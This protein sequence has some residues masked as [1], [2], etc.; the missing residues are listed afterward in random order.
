[1]AVFGQITD[2]RG[3]PA[4]TLTDSALRS[5]WGARSGC[6]S[7][8]K[9]RDA[10]VDGHRQCRCP[11]GLVRQ[12][13]HDGVGDLHRLHDAVWVEVGVGAQQVLVSSGDLTERGEMC[14]DISV[15]TGPGCTVLTRIRCLPS[16]AA[17]VFPMPVTANFEAV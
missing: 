12:Q 15:S 14:R 4:S 13:V 5:G 17:K 11:G 9:C 16:S 10:P 1:M 3:Y 7:R 2:L 8:L 6:P